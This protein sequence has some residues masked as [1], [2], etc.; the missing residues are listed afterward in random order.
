MKFFSSRLDMVSPNATAAITPQ[1]M[2]A[3]ATFM[4]SN[5]VMPGIWGECQ[6]PGD[7][8]SSG[9]DTGDRDDRLVRDSCVARVTR[10]S[11]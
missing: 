7:L 5:T 6:G 4:P 11:A 3:A 2:P 10:E 8:R 1:P 9:G